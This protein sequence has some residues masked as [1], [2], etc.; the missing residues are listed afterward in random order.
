[1]VN[2]VTA[3]CNLSVT[4]RKHSFPGI[5][6]FE[7]FSLFSCEELN[8]EVCPSILDTPFMCMNLIDS[9]FVPCKCEVNFG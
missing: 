6:L 1:M 2:V 4:L 7:I 9:D 5:C 3:E 8:H